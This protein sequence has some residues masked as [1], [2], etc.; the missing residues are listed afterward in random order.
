MTQCLTISL[1]LPPCHSLTQF[2]YHQI[3]Y[4]ILMIQ[5]LVNRR[6]MKTKL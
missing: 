5:N 2:R 3:I 1:C 4:R 6:A